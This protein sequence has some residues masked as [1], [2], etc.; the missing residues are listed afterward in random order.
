MVLLVAL[1]AQRRVYI[2]KIRHLK[3]FLPRFALKMG[4]VTPYEDGK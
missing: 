4:F 2:D 3:S 1:A